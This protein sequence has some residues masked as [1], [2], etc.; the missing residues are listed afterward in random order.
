ML[1]SDGQ[2]GH[3][4]LVFATIGR[5]VSIIS[6]VA[7]NSNAHDATLTPAQVPSRLVDWSTKPGLPL[8]ARGA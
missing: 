7:S 8:T 3:A 5:P 1:E 6:V 2:Q 4:Q